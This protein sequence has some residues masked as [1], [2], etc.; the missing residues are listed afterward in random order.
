MATLV[1]K[2]TEVEYSRRQFVARQNSVDW[3][4]LFVNSYVR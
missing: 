3:A 4:D 2:V 1:A